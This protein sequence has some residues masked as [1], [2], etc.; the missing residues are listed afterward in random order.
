MEKK[1]RE[2]HKQLSKQ[3]D[4]LNTRLVVLLRLMREFTSSPDITDR[5]ASAGEQQFLANKI[6]SVKK[7]IARAQ[8]AMKL[9]EDD[10]YGVCIDCGRDI[11]K[12]RLDAV[13][14]ARRCIECQDRKEQGLPALVA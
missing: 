11:T 1:W 4:E 13:P 14:T 8:R 5:A 12:K 7:Q 10:E 2:K 6:E 3:L 9:I